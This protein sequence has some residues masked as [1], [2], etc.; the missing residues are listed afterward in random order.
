MARPERHALWLVVPVALAM[1]PHALYVPAW[2]S[3][4]AALALVWR[5]SP[6]WLKEG[7]AQ[8]AA[9]LLLA[10]AAVLAVLLQFRTLAGPEAGIALLVLAVALKLLESD[11]RRDHAIAV[12][13]GYFLAVATLIH[14]Q[15]IAAAAWLLVTTAVLTAALAAGQAAQPPAPAAALRLGAVLVAQALP[16]AVLL[17]L[18]FPRLAA[19]LG[20]L[21]H[22]ETGRSGLSDS[23][24]PGS[25]SR[26]ILSDAVA[27]RVDFAD[28]AVDA[29]GLYWRGPVLAEF[30]G[31]TW[32]RGEPRPAPPPA[33]PVGG[34]LD[35]TVTLEASGQPWLPVA[36]LAE[37]M[38]LPSARL[39]GDMEWRTRLP[40]HGRLRYTVTAWRDYRL[41]P[42]L[43]PY[44][45]AQ[46]L[47]LPA[48]RHP[49]AHALARQWAEQSASPRAIVERA[50]AHFR[51]EPF[52]YTLNPPVLGDD[53]VDDFLFRSRRGF[54]EH[55]AG[56]FTVLMRAAGVPARVITGYQGGERNPIGGY[57]IVRDRDAH[58]WAEVWL[59]GAGWRR[60]D[61][62]AAVAPERVELGL[63]AALPAAERPLLDLPPAWQ[64][65]LRQGWDWLDNGWNQWVLG[66]DQQ[67][68]RRLLGALSPR[69]ASLDGMLWATLAG[70][71]LILAGL[72]LSILHVRRDRPAGATER[73]YA[74][75]LARL[76]RVGLVK[77]AA[78]GPVAFAARA[79]RDRPDLAGPVRA[80][81][82]LYVALRY[83][84]A[85]R[86]E[87][88]RQALAGFRPGRPPRRA[89]RGKVIVD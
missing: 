13:A 82:A 87:H 21:V 83:G 80:I 77:G 23:M 40:D 59:E 22:S 8:R 42:Q 89:K 45:R 67:R 34:R 4:A 73:L 6:A 25:V 32:R 84:D 46:V 79:A 36:G 24:A 74:R 72:A 44:R 20:G 65:R 58:A 52:H 68:Q 11:G 33:T 38:A 53:T 19:P 54:C 27:M 70:T 64:L 57:W 43:S 81:T 55:Y 49:Q 69:L 35:Y 5:L 28:P 47:A 48:G 15:E 30:D 78:E 71:A 7:G 86:P 12:L 9:R 1:L 63:D 10:P 75:F 17:F 56:A 14:H 3:L 39:S 2:V 29:R 50:L 62:T 88:L 41:E 76:A 85:T 51:Q 31:L 16:L 61:P 26:L 18:L 37:D 60:V 66:Y